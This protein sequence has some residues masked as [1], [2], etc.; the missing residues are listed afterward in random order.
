LS[1]KK[2]GESE[3]KPNTFC[4][5]LQNIKK[6]IKES[7]RRDKGEK[8]ESPLKEQN[9]LMC[10]RSQIH[11]VYNNND[12]KMELY[13]MIKSNENRPRALTTRESLT[14]DSIHR[15]SATL[16][17]GARYILNPFNNRTIVC[18]TMALNEP[19]VQ[20]KP[21]FE[22]PIYRTASTSVGKRVVAITKPT[23]TR[24]M[25]FQLSGDSDGQYSKKLKNF[26]D[27]LFK[28]NYSNNI[29][30]PFELARPDEAAPK[31]KAFLGKGN[32]CLLVKSLMKRRFWW[33]L[34][35][36][37]DTSSVQFFWTQN[38]LD[39]I[40]ASQQESQRVTPSEEKLARRKQQ[41]E[42]FDLNRKILSLDKCQTV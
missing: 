13:K 28:I 37:P 7:E 16:E 14:R 10:V 22:A 42:V 23:Q 1:R 4:T 39:N 17:P 31:Y 38:I 21:L 30:V 18:F 2:L 6:S 3:S 25:C 40:H 11:Q 32:N 29:Y 15:D 34:V 5:M 19:Q 33:E 41:D 8:E 12:Q 35:D 36:Q 9:D 24:A 26:L 27:F 20:K